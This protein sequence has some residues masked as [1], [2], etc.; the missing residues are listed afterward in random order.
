MVSGADERGDADADA[1]SQGRIIMHAVVCEGLHL[2][3]ERLRGDL[4]AAILDWLRGVI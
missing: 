4:L 2:E 1:V 3:A